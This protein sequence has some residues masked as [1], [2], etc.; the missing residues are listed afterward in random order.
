M[1]PIL[2]KQPR[3]SRRYFF[4]VSL[5]FVLALT[6]C[7]KQGQQVLDSL[8]PN[9]SHTPT[10]YPTET[11]R[12]TETSTPSTTPTV[13]ETSTPTHT[14]TP[15]IQATRMAEEAIYD[16]SLRNLVSSFQNSSSLNV[17]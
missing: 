8:D 17:L 6:A 16:K 9:A 10:E 2:K 7:A 14:P 12:P 13:T 1:H 11:P 3:I 15:D 5:V 4:M